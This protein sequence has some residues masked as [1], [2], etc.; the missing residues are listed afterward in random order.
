MESPSAS[1]SGG[2]LEPRQPLPASPAD[3]APRQGGT[4]IMPLATPHART[5]SATVASV[6]GSVTEPA[7]ESPSLAD[8]SFLP[9]FLAER[10]VPCP[11]CHYN[12]R[13]AGRGGT[14][15]EC[16]KPVQLGVVGTRRA[17]VML[18]VVLGLIWVFL[19]AGMNGARQA[20]AV[21][22][23]AQPVA[24]AFPGFTVTG[25]SF[26]LST[27]GRQ[28]V[29]T[30]SSTNGS[31]PVVTVSPATP[32]APAAAGSPPAPIPTPTIAPQGS[33]GGPITITVPRGVQGTR[34]TAPRAVNVPGMP[35]GMAPLFA[36]AA[37]PTTPGVPVWSQVAT[38]DWVLLGWWIG[39]AILAIVG[40]IVVLLVRRRAKRQGESRVA[41]R[42]VVAWASVLFLAY[43][44]YHA[45]A[46]V[47]DVRGW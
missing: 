46:F 15:P 43:A 21:Y 27:G 34:A 14:C 4:S 25:S 2:L 24:F 44:G 38:T 35:A 28:R 9:A 37:S 23:A 26:T 32:A 5:T 1:K 16:G 19:A 31:A 42:V 45:Q 30:W 12:L 29:T 18:A 6:A 22:V 7:A 10:D 41:S 47:R 39:L 20:R 33:L 3:E 40:L 11:H 13:G 17:G 8:D 36:A